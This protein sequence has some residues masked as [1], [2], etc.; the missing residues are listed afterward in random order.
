MV[1]VL[2]KRRLSKQLG[3]N[4]RKVVSIQVVELGLAQALVQLL[5]DWLGLQVLILAWHRC[6][7]DWL[8]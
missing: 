8:E 4:K 2:L 7:L 1:V 6:C 5:E 3:R